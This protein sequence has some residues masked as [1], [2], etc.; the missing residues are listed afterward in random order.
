MR[1]FDF[2]HALHLFLSFSFFLPLFLPLFLFL[3]LSL[4]Y[5]VKIQV[6][7]QSAAAAYPLVQ[8]ASAAFTPVSTSAAFTPVSTPGRTAVANRRTALANRSSSGSLV[9][10]SGTLLT[11]SSDTSG[12]SSRG[13]ALKVSSVSDL[14]QQLS[15]FDVLVPRT[16]HHS[17]ALSPTF[18][19]LPKPRSP[20]GVRDASNSHHVIPANAHNTYNRHSAQDLAYLHSDDFDSYRKTAVSDRPPDSPEVR[21]TAAPLAANTLWEQ[22]QQRED[23]WTFE[24]KRKLKLEPQPVSVS[25]QQP[26]APR[27]QQRHHREEVTRQMALRVIKVRQRQ[28]LFLTT[29]TTS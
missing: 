4:S 15:E 16:G 27:Q 11:G 24:E 6:Q 3:S 12:T 5:L 21:R 22:Q 19:S 25:S 8:D 13:G 1:L 9:S 7:A 18:T 17:A 26:L 23:T 2:K 29:L 10:T 14:P 20:R 28:A